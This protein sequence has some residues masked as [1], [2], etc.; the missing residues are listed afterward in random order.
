MLLFLALNCPLFNASK[1]SC[2]S[3]QL[4]HYRT[5]PSVLRVYLTYTHSFAGFRHLGIQLSFRKVSSLGTVSSGFGHAGTEE[6]CG[7]FLQVLFF[8]THTPQFPWGSPSHGSTGLCPY[9][10]SLHLI[11]GVETDSV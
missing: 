10:P 11:Q 9:I 8:C 7:T 2:P 5:R 3:R 4:P 1:R 6:T